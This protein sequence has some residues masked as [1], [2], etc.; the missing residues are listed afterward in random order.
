MCT[1]P[2]RSISPVFIPAW[3]MLVISFSIFG[4]N[5]VS[6]TLSTAQPMPMITNGSRLLLYLR[7][8]F[9]EL[10]KLCGFSAALIPPRGPPPVVFIS[11]CPRL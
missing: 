7:I 3:I 1:I 6:T 8:I 5:S 9:T 11:T 2:S 10:R 4:P